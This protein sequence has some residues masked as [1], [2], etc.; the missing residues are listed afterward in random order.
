MSSLISATSMSDSASRLPADCFATA[1]VP[2]Y[3]G[4]DTIA[5]V[6]DPSGILWLDDDFRVGDLSFELYESMLPAVKN[7]LRILRELESSA[8]RLFRRFICG[9]RSRDE[10]S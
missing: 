9:E 4:A 10:E 3:W 5:E 7:N 2:V 8:D 6:F 1:T